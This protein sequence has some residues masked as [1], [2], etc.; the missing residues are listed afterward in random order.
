[1]KATRP[2]AV[3]RAHNVHDGGGN[4]PEATKVFLAGMR[5]LDADFGVITE[6]KSLVRHLRAAA[7]AHGLTVI[8][9][10]PLPARPGQP[11][12][13]QGDT[14]LLLRDELVRRT[15]TDVMDLLWIVRRYS[16]WHT[17]RED[18]I[19][20]TRGPVR[21]IRAVHLPPGGPSDRRNGSAWAEQMRDALAWAGRGG[22]RAIV[23]DIN[24]SKQQL[25]AF[26][27]RYEG[28]HA[29]RV[30]GAHI[31]GYGPDLM[32]VVGGR[33]TASKGPM[34]N[35]DHP[36]VVFGITARGKVAAI[37]RWLNRRARRAH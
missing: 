22:C 19:G 28:P 12:P 37:R 23:G 20:M 3:G 5:A 14:T 34:E 21:G 33:G 26:I 18:Q 27:D 17:P 15:A 32:I 24:V 16:R 4:A 2:D 30:R 36:V 8:T 29:D 10:D 9:R 13:E 11:I 31:V 35:S 25:L 7:P 6:S 1:M